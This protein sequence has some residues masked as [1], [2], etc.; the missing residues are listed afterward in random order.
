VS[1]SRFHHVRIRHISAAEQPKRLRRVIVPSLL[2][3]LIFY[4]LLYTA[5]GNRGWYTL[6]HREYQLGQARQRLMVLEAEHATLKKRVQ[7]MHPDHLDLDMLD[8][9]ARRELRLVH[10]DDI[11]V[12]G[13]TPVIDTMTRPTP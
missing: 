2:L 6:G 11:V 12:I 8:E 4:F 1:S 7:S 9:L 10:P 13:T 3:I 5:F